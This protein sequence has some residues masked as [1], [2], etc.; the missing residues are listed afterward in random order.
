MHFRFFQA[1]PCPISGKMSGGGG[2]A[3]KRVQQEH[4]SAGE[5]MRS[6]ARLFL[7]AGFASAFTKTSVAP[8]DRVRT[9]AQTG[10]AQSS[11]RGIAPIFRSVVQQDGFRGLWK[12]NVRLRVRVGHG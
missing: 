10:V 8:L 3:P 11:S 1:E 6:G 12:G 9:I 7:V 5:E 4:A 2:A